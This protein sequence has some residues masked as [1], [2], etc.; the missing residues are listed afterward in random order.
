VDDL[1]GVVLPTIKTLPCRITRL[2]HLADDVIRVALRLPP[3]ADFEFIPGQYIEVIGP[4][5]IRRSYSLANA[6]FKDKL[7]ELHIRYVADGVMSHYWFNQAKLN[8]MLRINGPMGTF[9]LRE[10]YGVDLFFLATGTGI[11]PIKAMLESL[12]QIQHV[13]RPKSI[14]VLWGG[15]HLDDLYLDVDKI[16]GNFIF[17]PVLSRPQDDWSGA[18]GYVQEVLLASKPD[19]SNA[20]VYACGSDVMIQSAKALLTEAGLPV[21][22]FYSD[23]FVSSGTV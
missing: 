5:G 1:G 16:P 10:T 22:R 15:R 2:E 6:S 20:A 4:N 21:N 9:F 7:L 18:K 11:A 12:N 23:A 14:A 17:S 3:T 13:Q 19:L 8:D